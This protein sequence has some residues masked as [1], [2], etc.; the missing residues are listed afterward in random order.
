ME[1]IITG[2]ALERATMA[3]Y[4]ADPASSATDDWWAETETTRE[5]Y[6]RMLIAALSQLDISVNYNLGR[7]PK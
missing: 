1:I 6:K 7:V 3:F 2:D 5:G 4:E